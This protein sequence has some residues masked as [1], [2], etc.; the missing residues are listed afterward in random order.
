M[1]TPVESIDPDNQ[2]VTLAS[3]NV[4]RADV[5]VG[6]DGPLGVTRRILLEMDNMEVQ[7]D[8]PFLN[9]YR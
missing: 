2:T 7:E 6:A 4:L 1:N 5:I 9:F 8:P 3:G